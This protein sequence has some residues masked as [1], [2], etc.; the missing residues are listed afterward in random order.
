MVRNL[1][2]HLEEAFLS[3]L[4]VAMT[5]LVFV[6]VVMRFGFNAGIHWAQEL[7]LLLAAWFVLY[8]AS[9]GIKVGAHIGVDVFVKLLPRNAHRFFTLLAIAL[10]LLYSG[11]LLYGSWIY[12]SKMKMIGIE[13]EDM[14]VPKWMAMSIL[15]FGFAMLIVRFLQ[16]GWKVIT[17]QAEGFGL[18]D[19]AEESMEIAKELKA[20]EEQE[21]KDRQDSDKGDRE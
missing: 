21:Q 13:L 8:G 15:V 5:L 11:L 3:L 19:E 9:Y 16:L 17:N 6:E 14:P 12:L 20:L 7:T 4:L 2:T 1:V 18:T 10:C